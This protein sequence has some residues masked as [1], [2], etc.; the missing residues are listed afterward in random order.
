MSRWVAVAA[1]L[2]STVFGAPVATAQAIDRYWIQAPNVGA[3]AEVGEPVLITGYAMIGEGTGPEK[4]EITFDGGATWT[5]VDGL[6][7]WR[8]L[9]TPTRPG[10]ITF[11]VRGW[12]PRVWDPVYSDVR[13][14]HVGTPAEL[15]PVSCPCRIYQL[16]PAQQDVDRLPV[17]VGMR[18]TVDRPGRL[19]SLSFARGAYRGA[20]TAR[21][22][23]P[24]GV[25]L[26]EQAVPPT[27]WDTGHADFTT[28][29]P[30]QPGAEYVV[31]YYT[32]EGGYAVD[33]DFFIGTQYRAPYVV[34][35]D[36]GV[37]HYGVGGGFPTETWNHGNYHVYPTFTP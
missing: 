16:V 22:W 36:A 5:D 26:H 3:S 14:L 23:G 19:T 7:F 35:V 2:A 11:Q 20:V 15:A 24:G 32:P 10:D 17:E 8:H 18:F 27:T 21:V 34:P 28:P 30:V 13:T 12:F 37:Y 25:L 31:S 29:V 4:V 9:I 1:V 33:E 6:Y